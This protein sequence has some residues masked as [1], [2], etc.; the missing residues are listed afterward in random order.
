MPHRRRRLRA[1]MHAGLCACFATAHVGWRIENFARPG[2]HGLQMYLAYSLR[3]ITNLH[4]HG[5]QLLPGHHCYSPCSP[6]PQTAPIFQEHC[7]YC[8]YASYLDL[9]RSV[10][11]SGCKTLAKQPSA[12]AKA[13]ATIWSSN[14]V[15]GA[16]A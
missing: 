4:V 8:W 10:R 11:A 9:T 12:R 1:M 6:V 14:A 16:Y 7:G 5:R 13:C 2:K 3:S 15:Q